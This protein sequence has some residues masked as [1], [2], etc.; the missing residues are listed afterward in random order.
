MRNFSILGL[1]VL[2]ATYPG[3]AQAFGASFYWYSCGTACLTDRI[4]NFEDVLL[5]AQVFNTALF[6]LSAFL[7]GLLVRYGG[8]QVGYTRKILAGVLY[9]APFLYGYWWPFTQSH[10]LSTGQAMLALTVTCLVYLMCIAA[11]SAPIRCRIKPI[12]I[13]FASIDRPED[14]P[15]TIPWLISSVVAMW[16]VLIVWQYSGSFQLH[17]V[18]L[19]LFISGVGD[20]LAEPV[21]LRFGR[22]KYSTRAIGTKKLYT[23]SLEGSACVF[24]SAVFGVLWV[25]NTTYGFT[26][27]SEF[28]LALVL[29]PVVATFAEAKSPHTWDQPFIVGCCGLT[30]S[31][32]S[33]IS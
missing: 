30:A 27:D 11:M 13:A 28:F 15:L 29:F 9:L 14:R 26:S 18:M 2:A 1:V 3:T 5:K 33:S 7:L 19:A 20:A 21:G 6:F 22:H 31:A 24:F 10:F 12:E 8:W 17:Y 32:I 4:Q 25:H 23:R 16:L